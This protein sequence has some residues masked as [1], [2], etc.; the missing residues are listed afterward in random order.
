ILYVHTSTGADPIGFYTEGGFILH[1]K[2][3][4]SETYNDNFY[5]PLL[6]KGD[7]PDI[8]QENK[9]YF[10]GNFGMSSGSIAF[11]NAKISGEHFFDKRFEGYIWMNAK[12]ILKAGKDTFAYGDFKEI[13]TALIDSKSINDK[14]ITFQLRD[15]RE[16]MANKIILNKFDVTN[17][18]D[19]EEKFRD[20]PIPV[21]FGTQNLITPIRVD[22]IN[23]RFKCNDGRIKSIDSVYKNGAKLEEN[24]HYYIDLQRARITFDRE[25]AFIITAGA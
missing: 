10:E 23:E 8:T 25:G 4:D 18:P 6:S 24:A 3:G 1:I 13:F 19:V 15:I 9:P 17:Y 16:D 11:A 7:I 20:K 14:K 22:E 12:V 21:Y 2:S 5:L